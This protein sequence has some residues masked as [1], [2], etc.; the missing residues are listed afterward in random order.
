MV[1]TW[2]GIILAASVISALGLMLGIILKIHKW[3]LV[4]ENQNVEIKRMKEENAL[5]CYALSA[6]LDGLG[7]LGANHTV[8]IA[9]EKL[10]KYLNQQAHK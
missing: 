4:Q 7:Q 10:D 1:I 9:K 8:P 5:I 3:Y 6:C 2:Q